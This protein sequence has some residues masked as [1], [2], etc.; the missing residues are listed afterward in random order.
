MMFLDHLSLIRYSQQGTVKNIEPKQKAPA[1][2]LGSCKHLESLVVPETFLLSYLK[3][4]KK[5]RNLQY[6]RFVIS[7]TQISSIYNLFTGLTSLQEANIMILRGTSSSSS[8]GGDM[9]Y[10]WRFMRDLFG[11]KSLKS[12]KMM[13]DDCL[14]TKDAQFLCSLFGLLGESELTEFDIKMFVSNCEEIENDEQTKKLLGQLDKLSLCLG[15][16]L[17]YP[18]L[19]T[20]GQKSLS[21]H[22]PK[23][24]ETDISNIISYSH[25]LKE[26]EIQDGA[27]KLV[28]SNDSLM[29]QNLK[30]LKVD[31]R[32]PDDSRTYDLMSYLAKGLVGCQLAKFDLALNHLLEDCFEQLLEIHKSL[33]SVVTKE[34]SLVLAS[35]YG[36]RSPRSSRKQPLQAVSAEMMDRLTRSLMNLEALEY[37]ELCLNLQEA[38]SLRH[39]EELLHELDGLR[40]LDLTLYASGCG[41]PRNN[42]EGVSFEMPLNKFVDAHHLRVRLDDVFLIDNLKSFFKSVSNLENLDQLAVECRCLDD[43]TEE[44]K[45]SVAQSLSKMNKLKSFLLGRNSNQILKQ[46]TLLKNQKMIDC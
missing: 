17:N 40:S 32:Y 20:K 13:V 5:L 18:K 31:I 15:E 29:S 8:S 12:L 3:S 25:S 33:S 45:E 21:L 38:K 42:K 27:Q 34:Y 14:M 6:I 11:L 4:A 24:T 35:P 30:A 23:T 39:V 22:F 19:A 37:L 36:F 44:I 7:E 28:I 2:F 16:S 46:V 41:S 9:R 10:V 26:L 43:S 1:K